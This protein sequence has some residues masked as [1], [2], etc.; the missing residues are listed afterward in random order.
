MSDQKQVEVP[1]VSTESIGA[2]WVREAGVE[3]LL[4]ELVDR[5]VTP[6]QAAEGVRRVLEEQSTLPPDLEATLEFSADGDV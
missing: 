5:G 6:E 2:E 1:I 3:D 4:A